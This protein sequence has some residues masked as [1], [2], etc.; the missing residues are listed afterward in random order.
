MCTYFLKKLKILHRSYC[1]IGVYIP[2]ADF[3]DFNAEIVVT[4]F[5]CSV[6][7]LSVFVTLT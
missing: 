4:V 6:I 7:A 3:W 5:S 1:V 2:F